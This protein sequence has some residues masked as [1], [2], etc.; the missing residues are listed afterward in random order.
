MEELAA[1]GLG[2]SQPADGRQIPLCALAVVRGPDG[3]LARCAYLEMER[4]S[5]PRTW[6]A[7]LES[8]A[9]F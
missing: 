5:Q 9:S 4:G 6:E 7:R 3:V 1:S 2:S 8:M